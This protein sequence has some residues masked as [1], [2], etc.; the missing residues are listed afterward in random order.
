MRSHHARAGR[1]KVELEA[2]SV[3]EDQDDSEV[4]RCI[5]AKQKRIHVPAELEKQVRRL[6]L[7]ITTVVC[8]KKKLRWLSSVIVQCHT[9]ARDAAARFFSPCARQG[10]LYH[11]YF[12][13]V[14]ML[15]IFWNT[16]TLAAEHHD[17]DACLGTGEPTILCQVRRGRQNGGR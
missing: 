15:F 8:R 5:W 9:V 17:P 7:T 16:G 13:K 11:P 6:H 12:D 14:V 3:N 4:D 1:Y 2:S 10:L